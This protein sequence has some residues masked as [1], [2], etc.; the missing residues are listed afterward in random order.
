MGRKPASIIGLSALAVVILCL[1][2]YVALLAHREGQTPPLDSEHALPPGDEPMPPLADAGASR[3]R[4]ALPPMPAD[5]ATTHAPGRRPVEAST[6]ASA[7]TFD[8]GVI[9]RSHL[10]QPPPQLERKVGRQTIEAA[11]KQLGPLL[12]ECSS[13]ALKSEGPGLTGTVNLGFEVVVAAGEASVRNPQVMTPELRSPATEAC[14][15]QAAS[16]VRLPVP[17]AEDGS[18]HVYQPFSFEAGE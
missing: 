13:R 15:R 14:L 17:G 3:L 10:D 7:L 8:G 2:V 16:K 9:H 1:A 4:V 18:V 6:P 5:A 12:R 11:V